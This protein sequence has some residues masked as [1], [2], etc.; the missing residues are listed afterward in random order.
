MYHLCFFRVILF[1]PF[2]SCILRPTISWYL[3][4][5]WYLSKCH[6][7]SLPLAFISPSSSSSLAHG[8][9]L[10]QILCRNKP[11]LPS[12][13]CL[14][15]STFFVPST[16]PNF[17]FEVQLYPTFSLP[18]LAT[19]SVA[20]LTDLL[21]TCASYSRDLVWTLFLKVYAFTPLLHWILQSQGCAVNKYVKSKLNVGWF[22]IQTTLTYYVATWHTVQA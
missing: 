2:S 15:K 13:P 20:G 12:S 18:A 11:D 5:F 6:S 21:A 16:C 17:S 1:H 7:T 22:T 3:S 9:W 4:K 8:L 14:I 19:S 10:S